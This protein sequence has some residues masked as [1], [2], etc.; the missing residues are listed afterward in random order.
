[1]KKI[2]KS[3]HKDQLI[4]KFIN[5]HNMFFMRFDNQTGS[6]VTV[7]G[8]NNL[9]LNSTGTP[10]LQSAVVERTDGI[11]DVKEN[12]NNIFDFTVANNESCVF[13]ITWTGGVFNLQGSTTNSYKDIVRS[14]G[15][16]IIGNYDVPNNFMSYLFYECVNYNQQVGDIFDTSGWHPTSIGDFFLGFTWLS[17]EQLITAVVPD[18]SNWNVTSIGDYFLCGTWYNCT[19][20]T[21][22]VVPDT[23]NWNV[24]SIGDFF[25]GFTWLS[26]EQLITAVVADTSNWNVTSIG[27]NFLYQTWM[28]CNQLTTA[29]VPDTSNWNVTSIGGFFLGETWLSCEQ[30]TTA[31]VP[32][33][34]NWN[35]TSIGDFLLHYTWGNCYHLITAVAPDTSN[36]NVTSIGNYFLRD[37]WTYSFSTTSPSTNNVTL[38]GNLYTGIIRALDTNSGG[39]DNARIGYVKVDSNLITTYQNSTFWSNITDSK[40]ITW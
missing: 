34:S 31:V 3:T 19:S 12:G 14:A 9:L 26:C 16:R 8:L 6:T 25:L 21:T 4:D 36:W 15:C 39:I 32:D 37:T 29:V 11:D 7:S 2:F 1:M 10:V 28:L 20:L 27:N 30:L 35:V 40:F 22:A 33:T 17:C 13:R 23:S 18:T 38:K 24:T 5:N